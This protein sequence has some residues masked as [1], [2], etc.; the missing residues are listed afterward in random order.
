MADATVADMTAQVIRKL[1]DGAQRE[2]AQLAAARDVG[3]A[4]TDAWW[5]RMRRRP[6]RP[7]RGRNA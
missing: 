7:R 3:D 6:E 4:A 1:L 2:A 5:D